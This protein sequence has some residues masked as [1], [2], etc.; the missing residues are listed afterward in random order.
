MEPILPS[1]TSAFPF[2]FSTLSCNNCNHNSS[3]SNFCNVP[4]VTELR[5]NFLKLD[6]CEKILSSALIQ[7]PKKLTICN[8]SFLLKSRLAIL[9]QGQ[10]N[11]HK[12]IKSLKSK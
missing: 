9:F 2:T 5:L 1:P 8:P 6:K 11:T 4:L 12:F 3:S 10:R 7:F